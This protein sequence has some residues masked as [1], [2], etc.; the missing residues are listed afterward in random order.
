VCEICTYDEAPG[1]AEEHWKQRPNQEDDEPGVKM[2]HYSCFDCWKNF[3]I[4]SKLRIFQAEWEPQLLKWTGRTF[5]ECAQFHLAKVHPTE[6]RGRWCCQKATE[7]DHKPFSCQMAGLLLEGVKKKI[8]VEQGWS[9]LV[10][11]PLWVRPKPEAPLGTDVCV[12]S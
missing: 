9:G 1:R 6:Q 4:P 3:V 11:K 10:Y 7:Y 5:F 2:A 8:A 12:V